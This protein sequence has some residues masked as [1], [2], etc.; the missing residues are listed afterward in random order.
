MRMMDTMELLLINLRQRGGGGEREGLA[1]KNITPCT[2][3]SLDW[4]L[5]AATVLHSGVVRYL[6]TSFYM[7]VQAACMPHYVL[8]RLCVGKV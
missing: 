1:W 6:A 8:L 3:L 5:D 7:L 2:C 4:R